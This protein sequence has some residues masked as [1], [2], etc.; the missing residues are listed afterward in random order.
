VVVTQDQA[1]AGEGVL[2]ELTGLLVLTQLSQGGGKA[3][4]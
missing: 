4:G 2:A 3:G 1:H